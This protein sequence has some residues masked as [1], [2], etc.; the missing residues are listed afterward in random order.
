[1]SSP[2]LKPR[3]LWSVALLSLAGLQ[4]WV[5]YQALSLHPYLAAANA[6]MALCLI[7]GV[8]LTW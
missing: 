5:A 3:R 6:A 8:L 4:A 2:R 1:M 7:I